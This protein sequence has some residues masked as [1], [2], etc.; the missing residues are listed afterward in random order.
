MTIIAD[1]ER[2]DYLP[3]PSDGLVAIGWL[4]REAEYTRGAV[5]SEFVDK[6]KD[7]FVNPWQPVV[8]GGWHECDL[9]QFNGPCFNDNLFVPHEGKIYVAPEGI[10]HYIETHWYQPPA[11]FITA[12]KKCPDMNSMEY[13]K[14][15]LENGGRPMVKS[16]GDA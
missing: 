16:W 7:L 14:A 4:G 11:E 6:L 15:L 12:V 2:C 8:S 13:K 1:L 3:V 5:T 9:C 10:V